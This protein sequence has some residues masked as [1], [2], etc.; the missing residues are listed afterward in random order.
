MGTKGSICSGKEPG[1]PS[2]VRGERG[3]LRGTSLF[4]LSITPFFISP[5]PLE[6]TGSIYMEIGSHAASDTQYHRLGSSLTFLRF[7][8]NEWL[9]KRA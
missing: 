1:H 8:L 3:R 9:M 5:F 6:W 7:L 4:S 2:I